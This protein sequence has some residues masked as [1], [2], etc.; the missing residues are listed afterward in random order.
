M[1]SKKDV[2]P[3]TTSEYNVFTREEDGEQ[4]VFLYEN[5]KDKNR[6]ELYSVE[7]IFL[8]KYNTKDDGIG[9]GY[10]KYYLDLTL[11]L[12]QNIKSTREVENYMYSKI[13]STSTYEEE[14]SD[15]DMVISQLKGFIP[16]IESIIK[17]Y[18]K[19]MVVF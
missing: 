6:I 19:K 12:L 18:D 3:K 1:K 17:M 16:N 8:F 5:I 4:F 7:T 15:L 14:R 11:T 2:V 9:Y 13:Y 10:Y